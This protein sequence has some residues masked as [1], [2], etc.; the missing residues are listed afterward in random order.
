MLC[1]DVI[2]VFCRTHIF[3]YFTYCTVRDK[4]SS[5]LFFCVFTATVV[6]VGA[7][8]EAIA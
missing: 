5:S 3:D 2:L 8:M 4:L 7:P 6:T 1:F